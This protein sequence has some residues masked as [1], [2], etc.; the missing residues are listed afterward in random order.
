M[1][2][3]ITPPETVTVINQL[4][5]VWKFSG[6]L[7]KLIRVKIPLENPV[8]KQ[9]EYT[10]QSL[11]K[12]IFEEA[13]NIQAY[14]SCSTIVTVLNLKQIIETSILNIIHNVYNEETCINIINSLK[15]IIKAFDEICIPVLIFINTN[16]DIKIRDPE[17]DLSVSYPEMLWNTNL[18][19]ACEYMDNENKAPSASD[20]NPEIKKLGK[21]IDT[22]KTNYTKNIYI[23][24]QPEIRFKWEQTVEKYKEYLSDA[25]DEDLKNFIEQLDKDFNGIWDL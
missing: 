23:M 5:N 13:L 21:W 1:D 3:D 4:V 7:I 24:S 17:L 2:I 14:I 12:R 16:W 11:T 6:D 19:K 15:R 20:K 9:C 10:L 22:Q 8:R 25:V 18:K